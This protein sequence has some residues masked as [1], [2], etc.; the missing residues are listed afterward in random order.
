MGLYLD[1]D[2]IFLPTET[3]FNLQCIQQLLFPFDDDNITQPRSDSGM[4]ASH[5]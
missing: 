1:S 5:H 4:N 2:A 3:L